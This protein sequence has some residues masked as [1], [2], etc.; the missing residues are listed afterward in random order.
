MTTGTITDHDDRSTIRFERRLPF[1]VEAV[2]AALT[3]PDQLNQWFSAGTIEP[4]QGG[5]VDLAGPK[6]VPV[7]GTVLVWDPPHVLEMDWWQRNVGTTTVRYELAPDG[8]GGTL[9]TLVH[10]GLDSRDARGYVPGQHA[11]LDRLTAHL[12]GDEIPDWEQRYQEVAD[13]YPPMLSR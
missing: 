2:W 3:E 5:A 9:L 12:A 7:T 13:A 4:R 1:P 11:F 6:Q 8:E 10:D